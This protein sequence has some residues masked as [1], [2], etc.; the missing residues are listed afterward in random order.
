MPMNA[1]ACRFFGRSLQGDLDSKI[2]VLRRS[3]SFMGC[4]VY[5][6]QSSSFFRLFFCSP[7]STC[8]AR[9]PT[10]VKGIVIIRYS[11]PNYRYPVP[12]PSDLAPPIC[13]HISGH[14]LEPPQDPPEDPRLD[15][16]NSGSETTAD[17]E[18]ALQKLLGRIPKLL[19]RIQKL[20]FRMYCH[21]LKKLLRPI[22]KLRR[23]D[24][25]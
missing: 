10:S 8:D 13:A 11:P 20:R 22:Q 4:G 15:A 23:S 7:H 25:V 16:V 14:I 19:G 12:L 24:Y 6:L 9:S 3:P 1:Y 21:G 2:E 18:T 17:S 5:G